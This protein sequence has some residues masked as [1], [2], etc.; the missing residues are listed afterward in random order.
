LAVQLLID[1]DALIKLNLAGVVAE[2]ISTF[3]CTIPGEVY[4][5]V[6]VEGKARR[7]ADALAIEAMLEGQ[8]VVVE[9]DISQTS[10]QRLGSG[11]RAVLELARDNPQAAAVSDDRLF[12]SVLSREGLQY[13]TSSGVIVLMAGRSI[14]SAR[15]ARVALE[16]LRHSIR[17]DDYL[18]ASEQLARL[19]AG[20]DEQD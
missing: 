5:E 1:A 3:D 10:P 16:R 14:L 20:N 7:Y 15:D 18:Q 2:V 11:E 4:R 8:V 19:E 9:V 6:V 12:L 13:F 17:R